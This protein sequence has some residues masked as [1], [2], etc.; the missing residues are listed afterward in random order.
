M[1]EYAEGP[2]VLRDERR[3]DVP[4]AKPEPS[5]ERRG[6]RHQ[7]A[8]R[9]NSP[10]RFGS[11]QREEHGHR[12]PVRPIR[13]A[14][15]PLELRLFHPLQLQHVQ[16]QV[17]RGPQQDHGRR[18]KQ[19]SGPDQRGEH[20]RQHR[21][22]H[23]RVGSSLDQLRGRIH[24][25]RRPPSP[26]EQ[27]GAP[28]AQTQSAQDQH[29][30]G[31]GPGRIPRQGRDRQEPVGGQTAEDDQGERRAEHPQPRRRPAPPPRRRAYSERVHETDGPRL[32]PAGPLRSVTVSHRLRSAAPMGVDGLRPKRRWTMS[33]P[34]PGAHV[35][36]SLRIRPPLASAPGR[37]GARVRR[38]AGTSC[39]PPRVLDPHR[40]L[41][42]PVIP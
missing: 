34:P 37:S 21:V 23:P 30:T 1:A 35:P 12:V 4:A 20:P 13:D 32:A 15:P 16:E 33:V 26:G 7:C 5:H 11:G 2:T 18:A 40:V 3:A 39:R 28:R 31:H 41:H 24:R 14:E 9:R 38:A 10:N 6:C 22:P 8:D 25:D 17:R 19:K 27:A 42:D 36:T 29:E